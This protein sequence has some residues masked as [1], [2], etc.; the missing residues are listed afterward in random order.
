[1]DFIDLT[2]EEFLNFVDHDQMWLQFC[3]ISHYFLNITE[4]KMALIFIGDKNNFIDL[5]A[6][7]MMNFNEI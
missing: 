7:I 2:K 3:S 5:F 6:V 1:M 4:F